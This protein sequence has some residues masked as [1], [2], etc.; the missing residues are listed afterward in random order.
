MLANRRDAGQPQSKEG[1]G[2]G[3]QSFRNEQGRKRLR[4]GTNLKEF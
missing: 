4:S 3:S 1:D 2:G